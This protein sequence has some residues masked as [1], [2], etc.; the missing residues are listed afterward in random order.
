M[1]ICISSIDRRH[2]AVPHT[3]ECHR[4]RAFVRSHF[5]SWFSIW[6]IGQLFVIQSSG[7]CSH[8]LWVTS[9][10][11][12]CVLCG[13]IHNYPKNSMSHFIFQLLYQLMVSVLK[14]ERE[15]HIQ[16][17]RHWLN[18]H[19]LHPFRGHLSSL[20]ATLPFHMLLFCSVSFV[21]LLRGAV[22][23]VCLHVWLIRCTGAWPNWPSHIAMHK[24]LNFI[25]ESTV[26][27]DIN[28]RANFVF[29]TF[30]CS[31]SMTFIH[32]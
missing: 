9:L 12:L 30:A 13:I 1:Q 22:E 8:V 24:P 20:L 14:R 11:L 29:F 10:E 4:A 17:T 26:K 25:A 3:Y 15:L 31:S 6:S 16:W 27:S 2:T 32:T 18:F 7:Q 23:S 28:W 5:Q 21:C 19:F